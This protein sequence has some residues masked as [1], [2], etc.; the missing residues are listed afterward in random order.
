MP[1]TPDLIY[2]TGKIDPVEA[3][4]MIPVIK[5][6][7][8]TKQLANSPIL[9]VAEEHLLQVVV[10]KD[11]VGAR[12]RYDELRRIGQ[13]DYVSGVEQIVG[14]FAMDGIQPGQIKPHHPDMV[15]STAEPLPYPEQLTA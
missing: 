15:E 14:A 7:D 9:I 8:G 13:G 11:G 10:A 12:Y 4:G 6:I 5:T 3:I 1:H 2:K